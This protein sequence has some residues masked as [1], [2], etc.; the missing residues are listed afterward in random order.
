M[1]SKDKVAF[2]RT[3]EFES[4]DEELSAALSQLDESNQR[5]ATLLETEPKPVFVDG[6]AP[7]EESDEP[8]PETA[9]DTNA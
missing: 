9:S 3:K 7:A 4:I 8:E 6:I 2:V 1:A 5:I